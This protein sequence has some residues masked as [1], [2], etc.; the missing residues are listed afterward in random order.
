MKPV[1]S[2]Y[3]SHTDTVMKL[4]NDSGMN[5]ERWDDER[6]KYMMKKEAKLP[7]GDQY[8][9]YW[10]WVPHVTEGPE[11]PPKELWSNSVEGWVG[12]R[13]CVGTSDK[14]TNVTSNYDPVVKQYCFPKSSNGA[15]AALKPKL[16]Q[17]EIILFNKPQT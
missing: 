11:G 5:T 8:D 16:P 15:W 13:F 14:I 17:L 7:E 12:M 1:V 2:L 6:T 4:G 10:Q 9:N 3:P